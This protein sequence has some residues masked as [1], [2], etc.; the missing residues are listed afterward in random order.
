[1]RFSVSE[2]LTCGLSSRI[3]RESI[4]SI[5]AGVSKPACGRRVAVTVTVSLAC[6]AAA[7][8]AAQ[9][10]ARGSR[11]MT[12]G[13]ASLDLCTRSR[14]DLGPLLDLALHHLAE[15]VGAAL[16]RRAAELRQL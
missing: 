13:K 1:M 11:F 3:T 14:H 10:S 12:P 2:R 8:S 4:A 15:V 7:G 16:E 5:A 6:C 9:A